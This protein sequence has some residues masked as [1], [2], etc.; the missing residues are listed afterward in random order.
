V[1]LLTADRGMFVLTSV[2]VTVAPGTPAPLSSVT[3]PS[4]VPLAA[5]A[6]ASDGR[7]RTTTSTSAP[8]ADALTDAVRRRR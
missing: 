7:I 5:C 3:V 6:A 4:S 1:L 2:A 8:K